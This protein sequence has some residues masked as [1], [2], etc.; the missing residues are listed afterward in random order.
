MMSDNVILIG[1]P[2]VGKSTVGVLVAKQLGFGF[3]DTD[4]LLQTREGKTLQE[5]IEDL[6]LNG[7]C[8]LE[9]RHIRSIELKNHVIATGG[10]VVYDA[11]AMRHLNAGGC[12]VHLDLNLD[13]LKDR[14]D[15][16]VARGVVIAP[17]KSVEDLYAERNPLYLTH[18]DITI[19]TAGITPAQ[20]AAQICDQVD[21]YLSL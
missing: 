21:R 15:D 9:A 5:L 3:L 16:V 18:A 6:G 14:L 8:Q 17:G 10:S 19:D 1:M 11:E 20:V 12:I 13:A 7:F 2:G 4:I